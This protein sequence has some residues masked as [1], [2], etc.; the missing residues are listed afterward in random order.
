MT[1][2]SAEAPWAE[3]VLRRLRSLACL[4]DGDLELAAA[5][6]GSP[7]QHRAW[8]DLGDDGGR[9]C[10]FLVSG[11][12]CRVHV[13]PWGARQILDV[14]LPGDAIGFA[15]GQPEGLWR[16][17]ALTPGSVCDATDLRALAPEEDPAHARLAQAAAVLERER[18][19]RMLDHMGRIG[20]GTAYQA[21]GHLFLELRARLAVVGLI[22]DERCPMRLTQKVLA[23][24]L[25]IT[26]VQVN[27]VLGQFRREGLI[28]MGPGWADMPDLEGLAMAIGLART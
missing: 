1:D 25:G 12:A 10:R 18:T 5:G 7:V 19:E 27:R 3:P 20:G 4:E 15:R 6:L 28:M 22:E 11:W 9:V 17:L 21:L 8:V 13:T 2:L 16:V 26:S 14:L 23:E 24:T